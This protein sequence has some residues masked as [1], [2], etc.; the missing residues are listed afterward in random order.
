[1][2]SGDAK[3][4]TFLKDNMNNTF[5]TDLQ[6]LKFRFWNA[7]QIMKIFTNQFRN[8]EFKSSRVSF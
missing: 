3:Y 1:M 7:F 5:M 6:I 8:D 2:I 4:G